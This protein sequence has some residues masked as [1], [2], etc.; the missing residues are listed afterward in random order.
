MAI[1]HEFVELTSKTEDAA[2]QTPKPFDTRRF[3]RGPK[4]KAS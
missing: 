2:L 4:R 1:I 3:E